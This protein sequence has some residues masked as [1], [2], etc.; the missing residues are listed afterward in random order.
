M[1][2]SIS[3]S[4]IKNVKCVNLYLKKIPDMNKWDIAKYSQESKNSLVIKKKCKINEHMVINSG[5]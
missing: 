1:N 2:M 5:S 4:Y 3:P